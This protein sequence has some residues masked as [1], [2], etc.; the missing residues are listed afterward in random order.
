MTQQYFGKFC[1]SQ[2]SLKSAKG[3]LGFSCYPGRT[4]EVTRRSSGLRRRLK[5]GPPKLKSSDYYLHIYS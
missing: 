3:L 4:R 2:I 5:I 1:K